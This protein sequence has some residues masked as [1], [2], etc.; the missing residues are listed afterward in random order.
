MFH[1]S[2]LILRLIG[3]V[4]A[5]A[6]LTGLAV[7]YFTPS[8]P[9]PAAPTEEPPPKPDAPTPDPRTVFDT[10]YRNVKPGV[11]YVGDAKCAECHAAI[12]K[13]YRG[14]PMGRS[15]DYV[16]SEPIEKYDRSGRTTFA[17][18]GFDL[19]VEKT[20]KGVRHAVRVRGDT[21]APVGEFGIAADI[22]IGSGT[23]GRSYLTIENGAVWQTPISWFGPDQRWDVSPGFRLGHL[24][25]RAIVPSCLYC[26]VNRAEPVAGADNRYKEPLF[27]G[28][29]S[30][31]CERCHGPG[32][33]HA[34]ERKEGPADGADTSIVNPSH[35]GPA[36]R[37]AICEQCHLQG[38][39]RV[40]GRGRDLFEYRPGL[41]FEQ[42]VSVYV[43]HPDIALANKSVGQFE[44]M[45]QSR[46]F[47]GAA[48]KMSCT[49][50]HDPHSVPAPKEREAHY[51]Q[52]CLSC[53]E[54]QGCSLPQVERRAKN[55]SCI[56]CHM[57]R[58]A[59]ANIVHASVTDHR[60][61]R[62]REARPAPKGLAAGAVPLVR[63]RSSPY[64]PAAEERERDLG[65]ALAEFSKKRL[66]EEI[67]G[68]SD[69]RA[70]AA[71]RLN[72]SLGKWPGDGGAWLAL[73]SLRAERGKE[74]ERF[75]AARNASALAPESDAAL[76][77]LAEAATAAGKYDEAES[78]AGK[79]V[80][81]S[82]GSTD[83]LVSRALVYLA[84]ENWERAEEDCRAALRIQPLSPQA[85]LALAICRY[86]RGDRTAAERELQT[87]V[88]LESDPRERDLL[89]DWYRRATRPAK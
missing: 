46:C 18:G 20:P 34:A 75:R 4:A 2:P 32:A 13:S 62:T 8:E 74:A 63:F 16:A 67:T 72:T 61:P 57:P 21:P 35:L 22:A 43:R 69:P 27:A 51:R 11:G 45:E 52:K 77:V 6:C 85:H 9:P 10:Q 39:Q 55:D 58:A 40:P 33:L 7:W 66:P 30:I 49:S 25:R 65:I 88:R 3:A 23:R 76:A 83:A 36:L 14:H 60:I 24:V 64:S 47:T 29:L 70:L 1:P 42:F 79:W 81:A 82:P 37:A 87:A 68:R 56:D 12:A 15:A 78:A 59:S 38:E 89:T 50:C 73:A 71:E 5:L 31:G 54:K 28:Q 19:T 84:R 17:S 80:R 48:G 44:Q 41:P 53:H 26:H 86:H